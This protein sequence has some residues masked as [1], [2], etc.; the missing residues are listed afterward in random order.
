MEDPDNVAG[1]FASYSR[2]TMNSLYRRSIVDLGLA[3]VIL[4]GGFG[5]SLQKPHHQQLSS[6]YYYCSSVPVSESSDSLV[7]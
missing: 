7:L 1:S 5:S 6:Y 4:G 3:F 2:R